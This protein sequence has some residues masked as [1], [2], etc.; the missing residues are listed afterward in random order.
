[1]PIGYIEAVNATS[2]DKKLFEIKARI[3]QLRPQLT[4]AQ[5]EK[6]AKEFAKENKPAT[7]QHIENFL[8][9]EGV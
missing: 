5:I 7:S 9:F 4:N 6:L 1:M 8:G 3:Q 2:I